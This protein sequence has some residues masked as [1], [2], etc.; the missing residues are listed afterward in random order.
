VTLDDKAYHVDG[1]RLI[2]FKGLIYGTRGWRNRLKSQKFA[3]GTSS[4]YSCWID[5]NELYRQVSYIK[6]T[7]ACNRDVTQLDLSLCHYRIRDISVR[8][9]C[10]EKSCLPEQFSM[11]ISS[12]SKMI[13]FC[14]NEILRYKDNDRVE[15]TAWF[16]LTSVTEKGKGNSEESEIRPK[17]K[18]GKCLATRDNRLSLNR[19]VTF[20]RKY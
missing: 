12:L 20:A 3:C 16:S 10:M 5:A 11:S 18:I 2:A 4:R 7:R 9:T 15:Q 17:R 8:G 1:N 6:C 14:E 13:T 19:S